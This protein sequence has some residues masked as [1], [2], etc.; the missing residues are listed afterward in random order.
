[1]SESVSYMPNDQPKKMAYGTEVN[2]LVPYALGA[3]P[4][5][6]GTRQ[7]KSI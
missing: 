5:A 6:Y 1:M 3:T 7:F 2:H 4:W